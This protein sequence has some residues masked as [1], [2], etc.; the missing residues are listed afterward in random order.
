[1]FDKVIDARESDRLPKFLQAEHAPALVSQLFPHQQYG[2]AWMLHRERDP[3][4]VNSGGLPPHWKLEKGRYLHELMH[5]NLVSPVPRI[6]RCT[7]YRSVLVREIVPAT[8]TL[9][10]G[11]VATAGRPD[12]AV[13]A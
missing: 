4:F 2:V 6:G 3:D 10:H 12:W 13:G 7:R 1:M 9:L 8:S 11:C 5:A